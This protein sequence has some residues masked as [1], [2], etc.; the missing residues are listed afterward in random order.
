[1]R[2]CLIRKTCVYLDALQRQHHADIATHAVHL[3]GQLNLH[4]DQ[5]GFAQLCPVCISACRLA[6]SPGFVEPGQ[7]DYI[8]YKSF[9]VL[10]ASIKVVIGCPK[11][12]IL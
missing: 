9:T 2:L 1:M 11:I 8:I 4:V 3:D 5:A 6:Q 7:E 10:L 12:A